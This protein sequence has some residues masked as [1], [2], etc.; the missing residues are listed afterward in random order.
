MQL[1]IV[2][3]ELPVLNR[4]FTVIP[5]EYDAVWRVSFRFTVKQQN[6]SSVRFVNAYYIRCR[7]L[8]LSNAHS[9]GR[10]ATGS[11]IHRKSA[12]VRPTCRRFRFDEATNEPFARRV[13]EIPDRCLT[14]VR[15]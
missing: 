7:P 8:S 11:E 13:P 3:A 14:F 9:E 2:S 12:R 4:V 15:R 6:I 10:E 1:L 5:S